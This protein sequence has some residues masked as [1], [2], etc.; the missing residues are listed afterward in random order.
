MDLANE[1]FETLRAMAV[2]TRT[3]EYAPLPVLEAAAALVTGQ[4]LVAH[5]CCSRELGTLI[6]WR[7]AALTTGVFIYVD[8]SR[9]SVDWDLNDPED[10]D[11][12]IAWARPLDTIADVTVTERRSVRRPGGAI[13]RFQAA[14]RVRFRDG[15]TIDLPLFGGISHYA[16]AAADE[17]F[18][19]ELLIHT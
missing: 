6:S 7:F 9:E 2:D 1:D 16:S 15:T 4:T 3:T 17:R 10:A 14:Y 12:V 8:G 11:E 19:R 5:S 18:A 13:S